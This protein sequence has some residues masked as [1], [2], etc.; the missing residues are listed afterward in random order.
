MLVPNLAIRKAMEEFM[1][2]QPKLANDLVYVSLNRAPSEVEK[3]VNVLV[4]GTAGVGKDCPIAKN[5]GIGMIYS[6]R[7]ILPTVKIEQ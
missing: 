4:V 7:K 3:R 2:K 5:G 1:K 6:S